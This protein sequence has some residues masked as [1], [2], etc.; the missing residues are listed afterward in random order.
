MNWTITPDNHADAVIAL[1]ERDGVAVLAHGVGRYPSATRGDRSTTKDPYVAV[2]IGRHS[3][4]TASGWTHYYPSAT[5]MAVG[6]WEASRR[7]QLVVAEVTL[8]RANTDRDAAVAAAQPHIA[9]ALA[10]LAN[11]DAIY[12]AADAR[13]RE[14]H[15]YTRPLSRADYETACATLGVEA[16]PDESETRGLACDCYG[17]RYGRFEFPH[18]TPNYIVQMHLAL[19]RLQG[20]EAER[21]A[22]L[23]AEPHAPEPAPHRWGSRGVRYDERCPRCRRTTEVDNETDLC[24]A[25]GDRGA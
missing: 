17:V 18:Y 24:R 23:A 15:V 2:L 8:D 5:V 25:C 16:L 4:G 20:I 14:A 13:I 11:L 22:A 1:E 7:R 3:H 6:R 12:E 10:T 19:R 9:A 21:E